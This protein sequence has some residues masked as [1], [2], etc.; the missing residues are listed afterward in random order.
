ML[1]TETHPTRNQTHKIALKKRRK[2]G[3]RRMVRLVDLE[4]AARC[5]RGPR[6]QQLRVPAQHALEVARVVEEALSVG[7]ESVLI[8]P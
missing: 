5:L 2:D 4:H 3:E 8:A 1:K 6:S 7:V